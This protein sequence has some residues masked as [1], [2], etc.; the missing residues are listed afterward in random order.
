M[1]FSKFNAWTDRRDGTLIL[2][3]FFTGALAVFDDDSTS[4]VRE[5]LTSNNVATIPDEFREAFIEDGY[6][7]ENSRDE[8]AAISSLAQKRQDWTNEFFLSVVL[9]LDCNFRCFY[10]FEK[11]TKEHMSDEV[12]GRVISMIQRNSGQ[13]ERLSIDWYGGEPLLSSK[14]LQTTNDAII[15]VSRQA[16]I[17]YDFSIT[18]NGYLLSRE[19]IDYLQ[20]SP[21]SY[22]QITLDGPPQTHNESRILKNG[23]PTFDVILQNIKNAVAHDIDIMVRVNITDGNVDQI[24]ELYEI[25]E[26]EGLKNRLF[27]RLKPVVSSPANPCH[28]CCLTE[29]SLGFKMTDIYRQAAEAGWVIFPYVDYLQCMGFCIAEYPR[30]FI[31]DPQGNLYKCGE[32]FD[33]KERVGFLGEQGEIN[34]NNQPEFDRWVKKNPLSFPECRECPVLPICMGGCNL[35]RFRYRA[36]CCEELKHDVGGFLEILALNQGNLEEARAQ[37]VSFLNR[38]PERR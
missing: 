36:D 28:E 7:V 2:F 21:L 9:N 31:I 16:G 15:K 22:L 29:A 38:G 23:D 12:A 26:R 33:E 10:C 6:L 13:M 19:V 4:V 25:M 35:K 24:T 20:G 17:K 1:K 27:L 34:I 30:H 37:G 11:H 5:S 8:N 18:T 3:N 14:Q 32:L